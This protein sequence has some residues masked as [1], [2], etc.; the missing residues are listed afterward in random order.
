[1]IELQPWFQKKKWDTVKKNQYNRS[2][3][4]D[5]FPNFSSWKWADESPNT[6]LYV[7]SAPGSM[8][9]HHCITDTADY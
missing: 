1:M 4:T 3:E 2:C 7:K 9:K 6:K 8:L 5:A